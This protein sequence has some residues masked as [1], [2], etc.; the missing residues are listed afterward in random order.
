MRLTAIRNRPKR[1]IFA[2]GGFDLLHFTCVWN[3]EGVSNSKVKG[4][5]HIP[6]IQMKE[7]RIGKY[8]T[9]RKKLFQ[10]FLDV[11]GPFGSAT[12]KASG[13]LD[14]HSSESS[15]LQELRKY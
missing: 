6:L 2:S 3:D 7:R 15:D 1:T 8:S 9:H 10:H 11:F 4:K 5:K 12:N 13:W 14:N